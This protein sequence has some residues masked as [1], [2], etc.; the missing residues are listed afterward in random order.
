MPN[1]LELAVRNATRTLRMQQRATLWKV[2][3]DVRMTSEGTLVHGDQMPADFVGFSAIG[4]VILIE[5]KESIRTALPLGKAGLKPH[6]Q[7]ALQECGRAGGIALVLWRKEDVTAA[8]DH[9]MVRVLSRDRRSIPW[10]DIP[11]SHKAHDLMMLF[12]LY[13]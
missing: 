6:Q 13:V 12:A 1:K 5:C 8:L 9:D 4:R 3:N 7:L 11:A 10:K 2:P